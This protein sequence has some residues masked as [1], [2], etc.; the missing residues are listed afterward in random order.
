M[1]KPIYQCTVCGKFIEEPVHCNSPCKLILTGKQRLKLSKFLSLI[2]RH[3]PEVVGVELDDEGFI[4]ID[5]LVNKIRSCSPSYYW[6]KPIHIVAIAETCPKGRFEIRNGKIRA[7][8]GHS[9]RVNLSLPVDNEIKILY[10][11]TTL[12]RLNRILSEG[13]K[14]MGRMYVHL[15]SNLS[16]A[17]EVAKR[18]GS[19]IVILI[20]NADKLRAHGIKVLRAGKSVY[21]VKYVPPSCIEGIR[22]L[23]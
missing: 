14:S 5:E 13:I 22:R 1:L 21:L 23:N 3:K 4:N 12:E 16:D 9:I 20:V 19:K 11:G 17:I 8:Y 7:T 18:H 10:H 15:S 6:L 2:L